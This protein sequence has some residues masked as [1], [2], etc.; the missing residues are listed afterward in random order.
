MPFHVRIA[1]PIYALLLGF[2]ASARAEGP[3][4]VNLPEGVRA[5]WDLGKAVREATPTRERVCVNGLWRWRPAAKGEDSVP[6]GG[7]GWFKVPGSWPGI[8]DYMQKDCQTV[9]P[10]PDWK[11]IRPG[12]ISSAWYQREVEVPAA[13]AGRRIVLRMDLLNSYALGFVDGA[14]AGEVRFPG[15]EMDLTAAVR[16]G[17]RH[18]LSLLVVAMPLKAVMMSYADSARAKQVEGSVDRRGLCGDVWLEGLPQG[19]RVSEVTAATSVRNRAIT[20]GAELQDLAAEGSY[21]LRA[22]VT[23][24]GREVKEL[25]GPVFRAA[26]LKDGRAGFTAKWMPKKLWDLDTP[27]NQYDLEVTL[28]DAAGKVLDSALPVRFGFREFWIDGRDFYLNGTRIFLSVLPVDNALVGAAASTYRA[29]RD[30]FERLQVNGFNAVYTHNYGCEPGDHMAYAEI[31]R[32]ADDAGMLLSFSMPHF[33]HYDWKDDE[34]GQANGYS[35]HA[36]FY[37]RTARNH[38]SVILYAMSH[39]GCGYAEDMNPDLFADGRPVRS[40][41]SLRGARRAQLAEAIVT[42]LDPTRIVYHHSGGDLGSMHT[43]NFYGNFIPAQE[44][45]DWFQTWSEKGI[46]PL[47]PCEWGVPLTWDWTMYRGWYKGKREFGS[48]PVPWEFCLAEWDAQFFGDRAFELTELEKNNLRWE[49]GQFREGKVWCRWDYP[50]VVGDRRFTAPHEVFARYFT[51]NF[52]A[53]RAQGLSAFC[54]WDVGQFWQLRDG[55]DRNRQNQE[56]DWDNLQR[57]GFSPDYIQDRYQL[58]N[59]A[60]QRGDWTPTVAGNAI[61][62]NNGPLLGFIGGR[63]DALTSQDHVFRPGETVAKTMVVIN[64]SRKTESCSVEWTLCLPK[65]ATGKKKVKVATG[66]QA[67]I[68][69]SFPLPAGFVPGTYGILATFTFGSH[70]VQK[71]EFQ[72]TVI[73]PSPAPRVPGRIALFDPAG[74]TGRLLASL[75]V[76]AAAVDA[77]ADLSGYDLLIVGKKALSPDGPGPDLARV[78]DGLKVVVFEQGA[79]ALE[80]RL[81]FRVSEY[82][83]RQVFA[84]TPDSPALAG[85]NVEFLRDWRGAATTVPPRLSCETKEPYGRTVKWCGLDETRAWRCGNRGSVASVLIEKPARGDF[86]PILEGGYSVQ[87]SPLMEY[88]EGKG[89]VLFCQMD[90]TG[91]TE[92]DPAAERLAANILGYAS[93]WKPPTRRT[94][95]YAGDPAGKRHLESAGVSVTGYAGGALGA[96]EVLVAGPGAGKALAP[97]AAAIRQWLESGG[98]VLAL[99]LDEA[100]ANGFLPVKVSMKRAEHIAAVFPPEPGDSPVAGVGPA[101]VHNRAPR[102]LALVTGGARAVGD[103]VLGVSERSDVVFC[104]LLAWQYDYAKNYGLKRTFRRSAFLV[105][106]LLANLGVS[107]ATPLLARFGAPVDKAKDEKRWLEGLYLDIPEEWDDPYRFFRW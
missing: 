63:P 79:D 61:L 43:V 42:R 38:P 106:R 25:K 46:K 82:G 36:D 44:M 2:S 89:M 104:Q 56:V 9:W 60:F 101:D 51:R 41:W 78:H 70:E 19:A 65:P 52:R 107:G 7:W 8:T 81:G 76:K 6:A 14:K 37:V 83:L 48:A 55:V 57:P 86:L 68:P 98:R 80:K 47:F 95:V 59:V 49:A 100:E 97:R 20:V 87:Y 91:R 71:D 102:E 66:Q 90:V 34:A 10:H 15:G 11:D 50:T 23:E 13:W 54:I 40:E 31:L 64:N 92:S 4:Y 27:S 75:G 77:A 17:A 85:L 39:N 16:P 30:T 72:I 103:G 88:R 96:G 73:A 12:R 22:R 84:R 99:G 35:R 3:A 33:G 28:E 26:D 32:A 74:E 29:A 5:V 53:L 24:R 67:R 18:V 93:T 105:S 21:R 58:W 45:S 94:A 69:V 62:R 1:A